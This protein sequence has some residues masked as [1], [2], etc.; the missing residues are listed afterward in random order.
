MKYVTRFFA[1]LS[2]YAVL[3]AA[4]CSLS[5]PVAAAEPSAHEPI[6]VTV[7]W[8][9]PAGEKFNIDS[10]DLGGIADSPAQCVALPMSEVAKHVAGF[11][12]KAAAGLIPKK[13]C[14]IA[15]PDQN[16]NSDQSSSADGPSTSRGDSGPG[17]PDQIPGPSG[18]I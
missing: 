16:P 2:T 11:A 14:G 12:A 10:V 17:H 8:L 6:F 18:V 1:A 9:K 4:G 13:V 7:F 3:A 5:Q 15:A